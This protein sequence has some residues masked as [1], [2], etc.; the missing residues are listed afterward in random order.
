[1]VIP[2]VV[3]F[4]VK[5]ER[6]IPLVSS[7]TVKLAI[8]RLHAGRAYNYENEELEEKNQATRKASARRS[9]KI[10]QVKT[11]ATSGGDSEKTE[12]REKVGGSR[13]SRGR[14]VC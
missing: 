4:V 13:S 1:L 8:V 11:K 3:C 14:Q 6:D 2:D 5:E 10:S 12:G 7:L 9:R